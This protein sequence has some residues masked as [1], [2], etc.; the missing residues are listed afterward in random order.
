MTIIITYYDAL[1]ILIFAEL[2]THSTGRVLKLQL[3]SP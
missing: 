3:E 2:V 1:L